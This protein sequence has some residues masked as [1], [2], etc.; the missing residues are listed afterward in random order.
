MQDQQT[1]EPTAH[2]SVAALVMQPSSSRMLASYLADIEQLLDARS[3]QAALREALDLPL[4]AV[5]LED[6]QLRPSNDAVRSWCDEWIRAEDPDSNVSGADYARVSATVQARLNQGDGP[7]SVPVLALKRLRLRRHARTPPRG[8]NSDR[9]GNLAPEGSIAVETS[10]ILVEVVRR[11][12][13]HSACHD[14]VVQANLARL[15]VLR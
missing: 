9:P 5:A 12:Y 4:I 15:A 1:R 11:W 14:P 6:P 10:M 7:P 8:F 3:W 13:A 2:A